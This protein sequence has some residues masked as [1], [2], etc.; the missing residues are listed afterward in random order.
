MA[1][2]TPLKFDD[3]IPA[4]KT[5]GQADSAHGGFGPRAHHTDQIHGRHQFQ[6]LFRHEGFTNRWRAET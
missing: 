4:G 1:V 3:R 6:D 2:I 5:S